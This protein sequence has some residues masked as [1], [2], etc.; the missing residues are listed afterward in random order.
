LTVQTVGVQANRM[1]KA[2]GD[3]VLAAINAGYFDINKTNNPGGMRIIDGKV[4]FP[5]G[6][7]SRF[8]DRWV[9]LT[10]DGKFVYG[11]AADYEKYYAGKIKEGVATGNPMLIEGKADFSL[12]IHG[13]PAQIKDDGHPNLAPYSAVATTADGGFVLL[14][15]DGRPWNGNGSSQ[16]GTSVDVLGLILDLEAFCPD[17]EFVNA[18]I[19]DGGGS[20][21]LVTEKKAGSSFFVTMNDPCDMSGGVRGISR[22]VGDI[23]AVVIPKN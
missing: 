9:G 15:F 20:T 23:I 3:D 13:N 19:L 11:N 6:L 5:P 8:P 22:Q 7:P 21:E 4:L 12:G 18:F 17:I 14:C 10:F 16:G 2:T 1:E